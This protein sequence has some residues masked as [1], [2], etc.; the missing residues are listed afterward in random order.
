MAGYALRVARVLSPNPPPSTV[1][2]VAFLAVLLGAAAMLPAM[3]LGI[4]T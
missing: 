3:R 2:T 1:A 4:L